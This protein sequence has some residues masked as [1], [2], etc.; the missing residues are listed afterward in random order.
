MIFIFINNNKMNTYFKV[1]LFYLGLFISYTMA[2]NN[3]NIEENNTIIS[4]V[5]NIKIPLIIKIWL[6]FEILKLF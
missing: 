3:T 4:V 6:A 5:H 2:Y 1:S